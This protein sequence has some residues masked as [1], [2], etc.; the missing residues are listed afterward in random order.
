ML[1]TISLTFPF[2]ATEDLVYKEL[3]KE[4]KLSSIVK[5]AT[6]QKDLVEEAR[7][8]A[9]K[10]IRRAS[11]HQSACAGRDSRTSNELAVDCDSVTP[12]AGVD[13]KKLEYCMQQTDSETVQS[14]IKKAFMVGNLRTGCA[15]LSLATNPMLISIH[16]CM[17]GPSRGGLG[18]GEQGEHM[19]DVADQLSGAHQSVSGTSETHATKTLSDM[20]QKRF[21]R[22]RS[23]GEHLVGQG[24]I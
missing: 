10:S 12:G 20:P 9:E 1:L 5:K 23:T 13:K 14:N 3:E 8:V 22:F 2:Q 21:L 15:L 24:K 11:K 19:G 16:D 4:G 6:K 18:S 17:C 7:T